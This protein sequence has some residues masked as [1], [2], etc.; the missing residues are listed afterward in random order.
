MTYQEG[1]RFV[2]LDEGVLMAPLESRYT[3]V[4]FNFIS[5]Q[6]CVPYR[7]YKIT[8][9]VLW[10]CQNCVYSA[11]RAGGRGWGLTLNKGR[12]IAYLI[13]VWPLIFISG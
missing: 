3:Q 7:V 5:V 4:G 12:N 2:A 1:A 13:L 9:V 6:V 11:A 8:V 10:G